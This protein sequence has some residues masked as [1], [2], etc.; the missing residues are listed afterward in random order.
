MIRVANALRNDTIV[1]TGD[2]LRADA[3]R[4]LAQ[5]AFA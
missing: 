5:I 4:F 2:C 1:I 3:L